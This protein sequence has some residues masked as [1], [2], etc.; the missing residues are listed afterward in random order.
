MK[1]PLLRKKTL[2]NVKVKRKS[3]DE[4]VNAIAD[5]LN[6]KMEL[7]INLINIPF[8]N[9]SE[10]FN[11]LK[12]I[13]SKAIRTQNENL[14]IRHYLSNFPGLIS[15][16]NL[17]KNFSDPQEILNKLC[18]FIQCEV[19]PKNSV[20]CLNGQIGDKFYLIFQGLVIV[21]I[22]IEYKMY[23]T[24]EQFIL[25]LENLELYREY[26]LIHRSIMSN[27]KLIPEKYLK[28][29]T[30]YEKNST[31]TS[32]LNNFFGE[33]IDWEDY[34]QRLIPINIKKESDSLL[35]TL[36][37]YHN[38]C[39]LESGK[40]FG[41]IA[42][43]DDTKR[44][45]ATIITLKESYF[46]VLKKDIYK[47][48]I[49]D[50]LEKIRR[51][52]IE[53]ITSTKLFHNY[54]YDSFEFNYFNYFKILNLSKGIVLCK[55]GEK[56]KEIYFIKSGELKAEIIGNNDYLN[57]I[58]ENLG[59]DSFNKFLIDLISQNYKMIEFNKE[60]KIYNLF[61]IKNGDVIGLDDYITLEET[62]FCNIT[63]YSSV[64][65]LFSLDLEFFKKMLKEK[66]IYNNYLHWVESRKKVMINRIQDLKK[67][68][69][70]HYYSFVKDKSY[71][72]WNN[73][74]RNNNK[75][76]YENSNLISFRN[77]FTSIPKILCKENLKLKL[78]YNKSKN[79]NLKNGSLNIHTLKE[80]S[81]LNIKTIDLEKKNIKTISDNLTLTST[82]Y[83]SEK[84][85]NNYKKFFK[86]VIKTFN[87][88]E[89]KKQNKPKIKFGNFPINKH[90]IQRKNLYNNVIDKLIKEQENIC[91]TQNKINY[92]LKNFDMLTLDKYI[93]ENEN[94]KQI[95]N[96]ANHIKYYSKYYD[97]INSDKNIEELL[98]YRLKNRKIKKGKRYPSVDIINNNKAKI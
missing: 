73:L 68:T 56:R 53:C 79:N 35:F 26:D 43:K 97:V 85:R 55:E 87:F 94:E 89:E 88:S 7:G 3:K 39:D 59:G 6:H 15:T 93:E 62:Y 72:N 46:G 18:L 86:S 42:L 31:L 40:S 83:Q 84:K 60:K 38:I 30:D 12:Y 95:L 76:N 17:K 82:K 90:L 77:T 14:I 92:T 64:V 65:E 10:M 19:H 2:I 29:I 47:N 63:V 54:S 78:K 22:P 27:K 1:K 5:K 4:I 25:Y 9:T 75:V 49:K 80:N 34:I 36:W 71:S 81:S 51:N 45:T 69:L 37:K 50:A 13:F 67:N 66:T 61:F 41:D 98:D 20:I 21:L 32:N 48:C 11:I 52:N 96:K 44:R 28:Q 91:K 16:L 74:S 8:N 57:N 58:I 23:L 33:T 70:L 24:I